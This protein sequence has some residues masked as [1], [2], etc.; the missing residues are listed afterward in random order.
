MMI[1]SR[2]VSER[3]LDLVFGIFF[4]VLVAQPCAAQWVNVT[5]DSTANYRQV[6]FTDS[7]HGYIAAGLTSV[8]MDSSGAI[9]R[10][11]DGGRTWVRRIVSPVRLLSVSAIGDS[12]VWA[13]G[14][15]ATVYRSRDGGETW[16]R[17]NVDYSLIT[18]Q[19]V[20]SLDGWCIG[21][22]D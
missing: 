18:V 2:R 9:F 21:N 10:T 6:V 22:G 15:Y 19:F 20:D 17:S 1:L 7:S 3:V 8:G 11:T 12:L 4:I 13:S 5:P 14:D 16:K